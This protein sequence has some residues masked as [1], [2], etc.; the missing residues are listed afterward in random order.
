MAEVLISGCRIRISLTIDKSFLDFK[1]K[2][3][4]NLLD[5]LSFDENLNFSFETEA[6]DSL[7][8]K[9]PRR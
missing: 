3:S 1:S 8:R 9:V 5:R 7:R 4:L 6:K 2:I